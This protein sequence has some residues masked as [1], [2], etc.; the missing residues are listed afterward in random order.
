MDHA[1]VRVFASALNV[2]V[3][4]HAGAL[5]RGREGGVAAAPTP[6]PATPAA[7]SHTSMAVPMCAQK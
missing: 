1:C 7:A 3:Q 5:C 2:R 6:M 4:E